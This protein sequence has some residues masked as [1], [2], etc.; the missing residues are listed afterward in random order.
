MFAQHHHAHRERNGEQQSHRSPEPGPEGDRDQQADLRDAGGAGIQHGFEH[1]VGEDFERQHQPEHVQRLA[2]A[3][4][5]RDGDQHRRDDA[6]ERADVGHEAQQPAQHAPDRG[7]RH[8]ERPQAQARDGRVDGV[9][10]RLHQELTG[11]AASGFLEGAGGARDVPAADDADDA[12]AQIAALE[13]HEDHER[14]DQAGSGGEPHHGAECAERGAAHA[15]GH[16]HP[17]GPRRRGRLREVALHALHR[18]LQFLDRAATAHRAHLPQTGG[19]GG[20]ITGQIAGD[21]IE[22]AHQRPAAGQRQRERQRHGPEHGRH[23]ADEPLEPAHRRGHQEGQ[24]RRQR[25]R[26][27]QIARGRHRR[28]DRQRAE[29]GRPSAGRTRTGGLGCRRAGGERRAWGHC[30]RGGSNDTTTARI[31]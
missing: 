10:R 20:A 19:E 29:H 27:Q 12:V 3:V 26:H 24:Q 25:D 11:N 22:L 17:P 28:D 14:D 21:A 30:E 18:L 16:H 6:D 15:L 8:A 1:Q 31:S 5:R 7:I 9:H 23:T 13:Q 4:E 2:P